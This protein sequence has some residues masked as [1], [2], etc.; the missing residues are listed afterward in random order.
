MAGAMKCL[1]AAIIPAACL[2]LAA[3]KDT[4]PRQYQPQELEASPEYQ[5]AALAKLIEQPVPPHGAMP[6]LAPPAQPEIPRERR[7]KMEAAF[8]AISLAFHCDT[9]G[10]PLELAKDRPALTLNEAPQ[11]GLYLSVVF[12]PQDR[13]VSVHLSDKSLPLAGNRMI[14]AEK[15][16]AYAIKCHQ[17]AF[18]YKPQ[19]ELDLDHIST[20]ANGI[21]GNVDAV[22]SARPAG[23]PMLSFA[24]L[25]AN[26][27]GL[28]RW[29]LSF[30]R[31]PGAREVADMA[32][33][34][35]EQPTRI[36]EAQ[37]VAI[38]WKNWKAIR[39]ARYEAGDYRIW[40]RLRE[41]AP[42]EMEPW[43]G[44]NFSNNNERMAWLP[45]QPLGQSPDPVAYEVV[46]A[47]GLFSVNALVDRRDGKLL[48]LNQN[49]MTW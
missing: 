44:T 10:K 25:S 36:T 9:A 23:I 8:R 6:T 14:T 38:A 31:G 7:E 48:R 30:T 27:S 26:Q 21:S 49:R 13:P 32:Q 5:A 28:D 37:A 45:E 33:F 20:D 15:F 2:A 40:S 39:P 47:D 42:T 17:L 16:E 4:E 18:G 24:S 34:I 22:W 11:G 46:I 3:A 29:T 19:G 41:I 43:S 12:D 1:F 35:Q